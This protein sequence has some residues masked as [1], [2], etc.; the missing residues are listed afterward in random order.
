VL[1]AVG[2]Y[3]SGVVLLA[4]GGLALAAL[5]PSWLARL[6]RRLGRTLALAWLIAVSLSL[7]IVP[8]RRAAHA[9]DDLAWLRQRIEAYASNVGSWPA[10][11]GDLRFR[12]IERFGMNQP[13]DPW[14]RPYQYALADGARGYELASSGADGVPSDDDIR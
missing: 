1:S 6:V 5:A 9:R 13:R 10:S 14:G 2:R 7:W 11:L 12:S 8:L 4:G 3:G